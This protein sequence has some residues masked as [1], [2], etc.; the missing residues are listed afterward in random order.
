MRMQ[1]NKR[2]G[3]ALRTGGVAVILT[4]F[5]VVGVHDADGAGGA[6][7]TITYVKGDCLWAKSNKG[8]WGKLA[9]KQTIFQGTR[10]KTEKGARLEAKLSD[11]SMLRLSEK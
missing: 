3:L 11:G 1:L 5:M 8:T 4:A 10:L 6:V 7:G 2:T 9:V